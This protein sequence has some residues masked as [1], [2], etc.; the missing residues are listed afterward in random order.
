MFRATD[1]QWAATVSADADLAREILGPNGERVLA[2]ERDTGANVVSPRDGPLFQGPADLGVRPALGEILVRSPD[3]AAV[4][5]ARAK[6]GSL[7]DAALD[8]PT[9]PHTH[10][11]GFPLCLRD[12]TVSNAIRAIRAETRRRVPLGAHPRVRLCRTRSR[13]HTAVRAQTVLRRTTT[14]RAIRHRSRATGSHARHANGYR[15]WYRGWCRGW[16]RGC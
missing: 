13:E 3:P 11:V 15:G 8:G 2:I 1:G 9:L 4:A 16:C 12:G 14:S 10:F 7:A 6:L 5:L